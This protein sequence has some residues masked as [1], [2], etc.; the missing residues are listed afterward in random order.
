MNLKAIC[1]ASAS[2]LEF[3]LMGSVLWTAC[4]S[5]TLYLICDKDSTQS[6]EK[7]EKFF[8]IIA[9]GIPALD[10]CFLVGLNLTAP[11]EVWYDLPLNFLYHSWFNVQVLVKGFHL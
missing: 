4:I 3:S 8:H 11:T 7:L 2:V 6:V 5:L 10:V 1:S 9:W